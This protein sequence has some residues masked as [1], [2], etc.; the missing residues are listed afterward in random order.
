[1]YDLFFYLNAL[2]DRRGVRD[3]II[4]HIVI[5]YMSLFLNVTCIQKDGADEKRIFCF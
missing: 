5:C 1:M 4:E 2:H 3:R